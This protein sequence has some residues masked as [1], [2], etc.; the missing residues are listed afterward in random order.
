MN[1][2]QYKQYLVKKA[3]RGLARFYA[4]QKHAGGGLLGGYNPP[5]QPDSVGF[6]PPAIV[7]NIEAT[8]R[9]NAINPA[10][11]PST[12]DPISGAYTLPPPPPA[13]KTEE[14]AEPAAEES[15]INP[16]L[17]YAATGAGAGAI[18]GALINLVRNKSLLGGAL[19][20][21]G[22]GGGLGAGHKALMDNVESYATD[23]AI[24]PYFQK[25]FGKFNDLKN[26]F[27]A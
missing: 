3:E 12:I 15:S 26:R 17:S 1:N 16:Y 2:I 19:V 27:S 10:I 11:D 6:L 25:A 9:P 4:L 7:E 8:S 20:G 14:S 13:E 5:P 18:I 23:N 24:D 21:A 22:V